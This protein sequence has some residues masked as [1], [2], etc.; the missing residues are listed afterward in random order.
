MLSGSQNALVLASHRAFADF[1]RKRS[2]LMPDVCLPAPQRHDRHHLDH[3][4]DDLYTH[5]RKLYKIQPAI[6]LDNRREQLDLGGTHNA[7]AGLECRLCR[8][9]KVVQINAMNWSQN[10]PFFIIPR[11]YGRQQI[12]PCTFESLNIE[13]RQLD[14]RC[15]QW[16]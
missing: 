6:A 10:W 15:R 1:A 4:I 3:N 11:K 7:L 16:L 9:R 13:S 2:G 12:L 8:G 14:P 5:F